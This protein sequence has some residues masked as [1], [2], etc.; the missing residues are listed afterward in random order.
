MNKMAVFLKKNRLLL[1]ITAILIVLLMLAERSLGVQE[2]VITLLRSLSV[3]SVTFLVA[4]GFSLIF[5]LLDVL[6]LGHGTLF[7][8]GAYVAWTVYVRPDTFIDLLTPFCLL[9]AGFILLPLWDFLAGKLGGKKV[10]SNLTKVSSHAKAFSWID[11]M[12]LF[13]GMIS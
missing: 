6:N 11:R 1:I 10:F 12:A 3:A 2:W 5:G 13:S 7:M 9:A 8:I 4:S